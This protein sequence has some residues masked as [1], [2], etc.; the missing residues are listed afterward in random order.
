MWPRCWNACVEAEN[1]PAAWSKLA[2]SFNAKRGE[3]YGKLFLCV[4]HYSLNVCYTRFKPRWLFNG[5][6]VRFVKSV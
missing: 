2:G 6:C 1:L 4:T 3:N 5:R